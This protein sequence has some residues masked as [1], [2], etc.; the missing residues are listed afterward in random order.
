MESR[1]A[2]EIAELQD[3]NFT[4]EGRSVEVEQKNSHLQEQV[5]DLKEEL[6]TTQAEMKVQATQAQGKYQ[7]NNLAE[8]YSQ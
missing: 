8:V 5:Y 1:L 2:R 4:L 3:K 7:A 6:T